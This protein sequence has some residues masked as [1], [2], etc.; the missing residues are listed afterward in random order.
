MV[1]AVTVSENISLQIKAN[2]LEGL[3]PLLLP[4]YPLAFLLLGF[5]H[6]IKIEEMEDGL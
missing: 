1:C 6:P 4:F 2:P 3:F 5:I